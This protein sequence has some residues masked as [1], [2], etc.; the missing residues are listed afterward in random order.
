MSSTRHVLD[1]GT[2]GTPLCIGLGTPCM[3]SRE[4][5]L[6]VIETVPKLLAAVLHARVH[7]RAHQA[8]VHRGSRH[9]AMRQ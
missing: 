6:K 9:L 2:I 1:F 3:T 7:L 8:I 4:L 5:E